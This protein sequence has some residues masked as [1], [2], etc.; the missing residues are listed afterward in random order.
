LTNIRRLAELYYSTS[1]VEAC[2][3][4]CAKYSALFSGDYSFLLLCA[5]CY[6]KS[7]NLKKA[8]EYARKV[9]VLNSSEMSARRIIDEL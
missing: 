7:N 6:E 1:Q 2:I 5:L 8:K 9:L 4:V 3:Q